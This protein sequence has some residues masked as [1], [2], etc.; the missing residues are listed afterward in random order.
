MCNKCVSTPNTT[1][2]YPTVRV[3]EIMC[4][5]VYVHIYI[6]IYIYMCVCVCVCVHKHTH[7]RTYTGKPANNDTERDQIPPSLQVG[8]VY[9]KYL[10]LN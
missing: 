2:D 3:L 7:T 9:Y 8:S 10:K 1:T 5:C 6:Y 4:V